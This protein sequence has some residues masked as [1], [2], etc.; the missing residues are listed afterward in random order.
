MVWP[1]TLDI[2]AAA[3][4]VPFSCSDRAFI[5]TSSLC[6]GSCVNGE[7]RGIVL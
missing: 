4:I 3:V 5:N 6:S 7:R 1:A 2:L